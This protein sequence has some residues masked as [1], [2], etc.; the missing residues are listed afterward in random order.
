LKTKSDIG[1][2]KIIYYAVVANYLYFLVIQTFLY[3]LFETKYMKINKFLIKKCIKIKDF[4]VI[5]PF[6]IEL[7]ELIINNLWL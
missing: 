1:N 7:D 6:F 5:L 3:N 2:P 4:F